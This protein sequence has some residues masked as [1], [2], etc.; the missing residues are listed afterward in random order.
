V[1]VEVSQPKPD[2]VHWIIDSK[3][4]I[5]DTLSASPKI[6]F[7]GA[8][9]YQIGMRANFG[10]CE[11]LLNKTI[12]I[13]PYDPNA[14][15]ASMP[16]VRP[17]EIFSISPNPNAGE[18]SVKVGLIKSQALIILI[19]NIKGDE[20]YRKNWDD[21]KEINEAIKLQDFQSGAFLV[22]VITENDAKELK[23]IVN[24]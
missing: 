9:N 22:R 24:K 19:Y 16:G 15:K 21:I 18:F 14:P 8:G 13:K 2:K 20:V 11:Y 4:E 5:I 6:K 17:I 3:A 7:P 23:M 1:L 12:T 10:D